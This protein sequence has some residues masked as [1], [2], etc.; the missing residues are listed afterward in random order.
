MRVIA[1]FNRHSAHCGRF[2]EDHGVVAFQLSRLGAPDG[3]EEFAGLARPVGRAIDGAP[4]AQ[5]DAVGIERR[6]DILQVGLHVVDRPLRRS[7]RV[8]FARPWEPSREQ[9][10]GR[11]WHHHDTLANLASK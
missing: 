6:L 8:G 2:E 4:V 1:T 9:Q 3:R 10:R 11:L 7:S 5:Q